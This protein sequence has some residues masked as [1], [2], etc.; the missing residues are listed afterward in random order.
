MRNILKRVSVRVGHYTDISNAT[1]VTVFIPEKG[2]ADSQK[3]DSL[4]N[5]CSPT[6]RISQPG[7]FSGNILDK[8]PSNVLFPDFGKPSIET[9]LSC[10]GSNLQRSCF[11]GLIAHSFSHHLELCKS[12]GSSGSHFGH[13]KRGKNSFMYW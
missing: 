7:S 1:S 4:D 8:C 2:A 5:N 6:V 9:I 10:F 3:K 12:R 11:V 13:P